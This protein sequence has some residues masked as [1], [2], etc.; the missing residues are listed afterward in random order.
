MEDMNTQ[1]TELKLEMLLK[2]LDYEI[3]KDNYKKAQE[4][5]EQAKDLALAE[6]NRRNHTSF[7]A[8]FE[9]ENNIEFENYLNDLQNAF[10]KLGIENEYNK[11]YSYVYMK[12]Y[13]NK[14]REYALKGLELLKLANKLDEYNTL[15][16]AIN[17]RTM[18]FVEIEKLVNLHNKFLEE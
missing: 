12:N 9:I 18:S 10:L 13:V 7:N 16:N 6:Y 11:V 3:A 1:L 15:K 2:K 14:T 5:E 17:N 4:Q 8:D